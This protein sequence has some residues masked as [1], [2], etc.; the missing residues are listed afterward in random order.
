M[1]PRLHEAKIRISIFLKIRYRWHQWYS[2]KCALFREKKWHFYFTPIGP[3]LRRESSFLRFFVQN[4][5]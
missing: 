1:V 3:L 5:F 2:L 4:P